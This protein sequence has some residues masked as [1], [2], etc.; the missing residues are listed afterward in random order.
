MFAL[1]LAALFLI[2]THLVPSTPQVRGRLVAALGNRGFYMSYGLLSTL[3]LGL[4]LWTYRSAGPGDWLYGPFDG[5]RLVAVAGM[6]LA[7]LLVI[8]RL[9]TRPREALRGIYT[10]TT[11]PGS[12]GTLLWALLHL[13]NVG[14]DRTVLLFAAMAGIAAVA[15]VKNARLAASRWPQGSALPFAAMLRRRVG[16]DGSGIG[17]ARLGIAAA[18]YVTLLCFH[19]IVIGVDPL[20]GLVR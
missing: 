4:V 7:L 11:I 20:A 3:A 19:P 5:A 13:L 6:P 10:V 16:F 9:T 18:A 15:A 1:S 14:E 2:A 12:L 8:G 17:W